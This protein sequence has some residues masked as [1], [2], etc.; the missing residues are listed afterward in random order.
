MFNSKYSLRTAVK[1][2]LRS[3]SPA[4]RREES[5]VLWRRLI[6]HPAFRVATHVMLFHGLPDEPQ[7]SEWLERILPLG[8]KVWLP[9]V[10]GDE[11]EVRR[12]DGPQSLREGAFG[13][14]EPTGAPLEDLSLLELIVVPGV[15]FDAEGHRLGR[16]R[17]YYDRFL[18]RLPDASVPTLGCCFACQLL[19]AV[20]VEPFDRPVSEVISPC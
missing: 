6:A 13:I 20:L 19:P 18:S 12:Y 3:M 4:A 2:R 7:T 16:G 11:I 17:G 15:A 1:Q 5:E 8:K 10:V 9:V 14:L